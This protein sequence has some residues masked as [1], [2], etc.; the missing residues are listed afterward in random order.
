MPGCS[1][2]KYNGSSKITP[3]I[4]GPNPVCVGLTS[5]LSPSS[6]GTWVSLNTS[7]ATVSNT[8]VITA[9]SQGIARFIYTSSTTNCASDSSAALIVH[10]TTPTSFAGPSIICKGSQTTVNPSSGGIWISLNPSVA[11]ITNTGIV[12]SI[13]AGAAALRF[14]NTNGCVTN[15]NLMVS[16]QDKPS[17]IL[18]GPNQ[19][20]PATNTQFLP[21]VGGTWISSNPAVATISNNGLV[22]GI[23]TGTARFVFTNTL[24]GCS[25]DS[26]AIITVLPSSVVSVT[27]PN[28]ICVGSS[29]TLSP[30]SGGVWVSNQPS[31]ASVNNSGIVM[32]ISL[33]SGN[34]YFT[35]LSG[36]C[37]SCQQLRL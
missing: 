4:T 22:T 15:G 32:G 6:G 36:G 10:A 27:G 1:Q 8:G 9:I 37:P 28:P 16:V 21:S 25:S 18:D 35:S 30:Y 11:T 12:T 29:T 24:S 20:C 2:C 17:I 34:F 23:S 26:S 3:V 31:V 7:I 5:S 33:G 13:S 14:T 19:I